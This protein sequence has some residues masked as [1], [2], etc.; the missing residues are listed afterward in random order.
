MLIYINS[1]KNLFYTLDPEFENT[2]NNYKLNIKKT[3]YFKN[4]INI[5]I[6]NIIKK[7]L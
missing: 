5:N 1:Y 7:I 3:I 6:F 4:A 2:Y